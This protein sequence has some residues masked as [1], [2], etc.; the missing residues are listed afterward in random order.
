[1]ISPIEQQTH[2]QGVEKQIKKKLERAANTRRHSNCASAV[3]AA[4]GPTEPTDCRTKLGA[5]VRRPET[6][7]CASA[8][9]VEH[10]STSWQSKTT[11]VA[12]IR[13]VVEAAAR[14]I[15]SWPKVTE[16]WQ[17]KKKRRRNREREPRKEKIF[18]DKENK[19]QRN[20]ALNKKHSTNKRCG[21][22]HHL[23]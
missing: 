8:P 15:S 2:S 22:N 14:Y 20:L 9:M 17:T 12:A 11:A 21:R 3:R 4:R 16:R 5:T 19:F 13:G 18:V 1:M 7:C 6:Q 23:C 10:T